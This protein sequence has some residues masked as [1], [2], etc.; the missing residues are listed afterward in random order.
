MEGPWACHCHRRSPQK[1]RKRSSYGCHNQD[2]AR[3][4][5]EVGGS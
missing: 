4:G 1:G 2:V 3:G 5:G